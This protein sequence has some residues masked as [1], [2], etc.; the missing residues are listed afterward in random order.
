MRKQLLAINGVGEATADKIL[1]ITEEH[2][3]TDTDVATQVR[4]AWDYYQA[5]Q[6]GY[7]GKFLRNAY[8]QVSDQ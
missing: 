2:T 4:A 8:E 3:T 5:D 6:Y 7:A 1:A